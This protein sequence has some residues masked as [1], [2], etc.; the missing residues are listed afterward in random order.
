MSTATNVTIDH[1]PI[2]ARSSWS[3][4][5]CHLLAATALLGCL[6][7]TLLWQHGSK[8]DS[9]WHVVFR[10]LPNHRLVAYC[11]TGR[12][13]H[14]YPK[15]VLS[16]QFYLWTPV[17]LIQWLRG[18]YFLSYDPHV[19]C[20]FVSSLCLAQ[21]IKHYQLSHRRDDIGSFG[22]LF[23]GDDLSLFCCSFTK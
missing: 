16:Q 4:L 3:T 2:I 6:P 17:H 1:N 23:G 5:W 10:I 19:R 7:M 11:S 20:S 13:N 15:I 14:K 22:L 12:S 21:Q 18:C 9:L 8:L